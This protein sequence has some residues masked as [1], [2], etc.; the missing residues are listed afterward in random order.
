M[1]TVIVFGSLSVAILFAMAWVSLTYAV[2]RRGVIIMAILLAFLI[3]TMAV[4]WY[5]GFTILSHILA[6]TT[7]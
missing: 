5:T 2:S 3:T 6:N 4:T 1:T 7:M